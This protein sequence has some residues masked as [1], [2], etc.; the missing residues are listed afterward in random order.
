MECEQADE[1]LVAYVKGE[2]PEDQVGEL[3]AHIA[4]C[5]TCR[6]NV[7]AARKTLGVLEQAR[8]PDIFELVNGIIGEALD[9]GASD[10]HIEPQPDEVRVRIRIDGVLHEI[11]RYPKAAHAA[12]VARLHVMGDTDPFEK[13][14][15]QF[16][17]ARVK[18]EDK[19]CDLRLSVLPAVWGPS[20][21]M[22]IL[23]GPGELLGLKRIEV[24]ETNLA[25]LMGLLRRPCGLIV[26][27]GPAGSGRTTTM[28]AC[29]D[30][31]NRS[32]GG[33]GISI[34]T[35]E[36]PVQTLME[37][38][39]QMHL[40]HK[41]GLDYPAALRAVLRCD[42]DVVMVGELRDTATGTA[43]LD[44]ALTGHLTLAGFYANDAA[45]AVARLLGVGLEPYMLGEA[46]VGVVS[47]RLVRKVCQ[48]CKTEYELPA[49]EI[50]FLHECGVEEVPKRLWRGEGCKQCRETGYRGRTAIH[51]VLV[52]DEEMT[53]AIGDGRYTPEMGAGAIPTSLARDGAEKA[54]EG[55]TALAEVQRV[56]RSTLQG[57][58][59]V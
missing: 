53:R 36:D 5:P 26:F 13:R 29:V 59:K 50:A 9:S 12:L 52:V 27:A 55:I 10:I 40:N 33:H 7:D 39:T 6:W 38:I 48:H 46:L 17:R 47:Q 57:R 11:R 42:P 31:L 28:Y 23:P 44:L 18:H 35:V 19:E 58:M 37:G 45:S 43:I 54:L 34:F 3:E 15:P 22:R 14:V 30:E 16:S 1:L 49:D 20:V 41:M 24:S 32:E 8:Q 25:L 21:T 2:L 4:T 51:E 56:T